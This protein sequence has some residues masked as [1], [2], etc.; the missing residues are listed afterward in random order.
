MNARL[1]EYSDSAKYMLQVTG[2]KDQAL[3]LLSSAEKL[4]KLIKQYEQTGQAAVNLLPPSLSPDIL[5]GTPDLERQEKFEELIADYRST[6]EE[7]SQK[8]KTCL[9]GIEKVK[10][11]DQVQE[12]RGLAAKYID[13]A[14]QNKQMMLQLTAA[15]NNKWSPLPKTKVVTSQQ[16][17]PKINES[18]EETEFQ[19]EVPHN[20]ILAGLGA[21]SLKV[22]I[23]DKDEKELVGHYFDPNR[24]NDEDHR[25][26][27]LNI[28][29]EMQ[30][31]FKN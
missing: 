18:L 9:G 6:F 15:K 12:L 27:V 23:C 2:N 14:K 22:K 5:F 19:V 11:Q 10:K 28:P 16:T 13:V 8:A 20:D 3:N 4:K 21:K 29:T 7:F 30:K 31:N 26:K 1:Q 25:V 17:I 24:L